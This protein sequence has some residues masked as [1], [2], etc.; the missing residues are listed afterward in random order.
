MQPFTKTYKPG[1]HLFHENDHSQELYIIQAGMI[2]I[3]RKIGTKDIELAKLSKGAVFGEMA[4]I[5]GKPRSASALAIEETVVIV[6]DADTFL[7]KISG[8]PPWFISMI[9]TTSEKIRKANYRLE[10]IQTNNHSL[11]T[12]LA[13][14]YYFLRYGSKSDSSSQKELDLAQTSTQISQLLTV[15]N[16]CI[17]QL[18]DL[19]QRNS[20][21]DAKDGRI[22]LLDEERLSGLCDYLRMVFKKAFE[23]MERLSPAATALVF[24]LKEVVTDQKAVAENK[25]EIA[26]ADMIVACKNTNVEFDHIKVILELKDAGLI[27]FVKLQTLKQETNPLEGYQFFVIFAVYEK[28][29]LY[30]TYKDMVAIA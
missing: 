6:I 26:C 5:D 22:V 3:Y 30:H 14:H 7:K 21:I 20:I 9:R 13:L 2:K 19:M 29:L 16:R 27:S 10:A 15:N 4:L 24:S 25:C 28:Y 18:L 12:V 11:H 23:K 8:V 1:S 17:I